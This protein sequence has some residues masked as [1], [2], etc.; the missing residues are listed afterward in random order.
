MR[1]ILLIAL[2][3]TASFVMAQAPRIEPVPQAP[4]R[5]S[6]LAETERVTEELARLEEL[7]IVKQMREYDQQR[8]QL[9]EEQ[10]KQDEQLQAKVNELRQS[11][12]WRDLEKRRAELQTKRVDT[13]ELERKAMAAI[14]KSIYEARHTDLQSLRSP[15]Q[16]PR[17]FDAMSFPRLDGSTSTHPLTVIIASRL[18]GTEYQWFYPE[19]SGRP[20]GQRAIVPSSRF[21]PIAAAARPVFGPD[22]EFTLAASRVAA[23]PAAGQSLRLA[24]IINSMIAMNAST[25]QAYRNLVD[26]ECD[27]NFTVRKPSPDEQKYADQKGVSFVFEPIALDALVFMVNQ[28][29]PVKSLTSQQIS[30]IYKGEVVNWKAVGGRDEAML[31]LVREQNSGSREL[32]DAFL[33]GATMPDTTDR[34][35]SGERAQSGRLYSNGMGGPFSR[36]TESVQGIGYSVWYYEH[37]MAMSPYTRTLAVDG[38]EPNPQTIASGEYPFVFPVYAVYRKGIPDNSPALRLVR[39]LKSPEG[40]SIVRESGYVLYGGKPPIISGGKPPIRPTQQ[41]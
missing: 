7:P 20:W 41:Q 31:V 9:Y 37:Y 12:A 18:L 35:P 19:P 17:M 14:A 3:V 22:P 38:I 24:Q 15:T 2:G 33:P 1:K 6:A 28:K 10:R 11:D 32:F 5:D 36:L 29:N 16:P 27:L 26:G 13:W 8:S 40:Q 21:A 25:S 23:G 4:Q 39:W 30:A 34:A